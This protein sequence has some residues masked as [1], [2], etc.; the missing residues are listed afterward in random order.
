MNRK[1]SLSELAALLAQRQGVTKKKA[2]AFCRYFFEVITAGIAN[3]QIAKV[4]GFGTF[5]IVTVEERE[6][7][8][9]NTGERISIGS[10]SKVSFTPDASLKELVNRPFS[11]FQTVVLSDDNVVE[12]FTAI[13][14]RFAA[15]QA[16]AAAST[17]PEAP[18]PPAEVPLG[19]EEAA[20][21]ADAVAKPAVP[22]AEAAAFATLQVPNP[23]QPPRSAAEPA[24]PVDATAPQEHT[25]PPAATPAAEGRP[26]NSASPAAP[27]PLASAP[28]SGTDND[29]TAPTA[30]DDMDNNE[31]TRSTWLKPLALLLGALLLFFLGYLAGSRHLFGSPCTPLAA[32]DT[33]VTAA[34][35]LNPDGEAVS[36]QP[37]GMPDAPPTA[38]QA[39]LPSAPSPS[40]E[41]VHAQP[42][43]P[44]PP[45]AET[46]SLPVK[47]DDSVVVNGSLG[48]YTLKD[49]DSL[50]KIAQKY[51]GSREYAR[52]IISYNEMANPD[53]VHTGAVLKLPRLQVKR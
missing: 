48:T 17:P 22:E 41:V 29:I 34:D 26:K 19:A 24:P 6:S 11:Q 51:Y 15:E 21:P 49:G 14:E 36:E 31:N 46:A 37:D 42:D 35:S 50:W 53:V 39:E 16:K 52:Y 47:P 25:D 28:Q 18:V 9:V 32:P 43:A 45:A 12:D 8:N 13:D 38:A 2:E 27:L 23:A 30:T 40:P 7:V 3:D 1:L 4:K 20:V 44:V 10:H 33:L 5:K